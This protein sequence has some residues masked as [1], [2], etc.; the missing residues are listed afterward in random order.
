M[1][2]D[3]FLKKA[4][5]FIVEKGLITSGDGI[6]MGVSGGADSVALLLLMDYL[7][8]KYA[9][10]LYVVHVHH[11]LRK[12]ADSE[13][14]YVENLCKERNIP[15]YLKKV[16]VKAL[17]GELKIGTEEAGRKARY[18][19]F[20]EVLKEVSADKIAVA[21]NCNDRAETMLFNLARGTGLKGLVSIPEK[22]DNI[23]RPLLFA[24]RSEIEAFLNENDVKFCTDASNL[25]DDYARNRIRNNILPALEDSINGGATLH[26]FETAEQLSKLYEFAEK[27]SLK[28]FS[29]ALISESATE[30]SFDKNK[31]LTMDE[32]LQSML[33]KQAIDRL[34]PGN[35]DITHTHLYDV[36][37]LCEKDGTKTV[38]L[39]Y[40]ITAVSSYNT[41]SLTTQSG[42]GDEFSPVEIVPDGTPV[43]TSGYTVTAELLDYY[44]GFD[45]GK[46]EYTK[47]FDYG[48]IKDILWLRTRATGDV[49]S[50]NVEGGT[51]KLN[52]FMIDVK[53]PAYERDRV[54]VVAAGNNVLW[55]VGYRMSEACKVTKETKRI[56]KITVLKE[57]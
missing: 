31:F 15:F 46:S 32:Y 20:F 13:A 57:D 21:H 8:E 43:K 53:I 7:R 27:S 49:I 2:T 55:V 50:V 48:K 52:D 38:N 33:I 42:S 25:T 26:M 47:C 35:R 22:R 28:A 30:I 29:E 56:I 17:S 24:T 5:K 44:E 10:S 19:A 14:L 39:P 37:S 36:L 1:K 12:E 16:D 4:E 3:I 41:L 18:E 45:Y 6:V 34:V 51:K 54:P 40:N 9:L 23:I 11:G